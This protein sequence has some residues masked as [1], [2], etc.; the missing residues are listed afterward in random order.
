MRCVRSLSILL[1]S[2]ILLSSCASW[3]KKDDDDEVSSTYRGMSAKQLFTEASTDLKNK[4]YITASKKLEAMETMYPFSD[5]AEQAQY[6]L[7]YAYYQNEEYPAAA[8]TAERF[9]RLY[10][11][12]RHVDY[13]WYMKGLSN[14]Q[15]VRGVFAK[16]L[17]MDE[18]WRDPGT[19]SQAYA[20]FG[21]FIQKFPNSKYR[22][23]ALQR[24][25][26]LR[27]MFAQRELNNAKYYYDRKI[28]VAAAERASYLIRNYPQA[29]SV[30]EALRV[31]Y[32]A[33]K[34]LGLNQ[35]AADAQK[36]YEATYHQQPE[37][38]PG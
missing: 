37:A 23:N 27:N 10:P 21:T 5:Y 11:R 4:Q 31:V 19:Q 34:A 36:V 32:N 3:W 22:D 14:F 18:S 33:N 15:Q 25:I 29:P 13:A 12:T 38:M 6:N 26:Y 28:Y 16:A 30:Q 1:L 7:I 24:M 20:D 17:P 2:A 9:I 8:A 35:A